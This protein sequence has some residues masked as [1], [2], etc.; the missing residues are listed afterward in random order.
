MG[1]AWVDQEVGAVGVGVTEEGDLRVGDPH[2][3]DGALGVV[4]LR[5][6]ISWD[7]LFR[8]CRRQGRIG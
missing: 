7:L 3:V 2:G 5:R 4:L 8:I 1:V 6:D